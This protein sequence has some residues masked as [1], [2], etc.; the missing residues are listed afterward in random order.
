MGSFIVLE[1]SFSGFIHIHVIAAESTHPPHPPA[2]ST[3]CT[4]PFAWVVS[5][6]R[7][8]LP[9]ANEVW[10]KV[11]FLH[12]C[13]ILFTGGG[14]AWAGTP[15]AGTHP[16][17]GTHPPWQVHP[18]E[19]CM[20]GDTGY[21]RAVRIL[22]ECILVESM[23]LICKTEQSEQTRNKVVLERGVIWRRCPNNLQYHFTLASSTTSSIPHQNK[24]NKTLRTC[25]GGLHYCT[26]FQG[27]STKKIT[28]WT[29]S[30]LLDLWRCSFRNIK[31][32]YFKCWQSLRSKI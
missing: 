5:S 23:N 26:T 2:P 30:L 6:F 9:P 24:V 29:W 21:K 3:K 16:Q 14:S 4:V 22:L 8:L 18:R 7:T 13:V 19:Q 15:L 27:D 25:V 12:L 28:N 1:L 10:G 11:I 31:L 20:L 32:F 17:A